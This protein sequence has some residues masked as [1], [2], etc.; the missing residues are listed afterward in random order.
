MVT[1]RLGNLDT[2]VLEFYN[3]L[4]QSVVLIKSKHKLRT[5]IEAMY[6]DKSNIRCIMES[7]ESISSRKQG[8]Q[9]LL[10]NIFQV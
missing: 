10:E 6:T 3:T 1:T 2:D 8:E 4:D 9:S 7:F 5:T